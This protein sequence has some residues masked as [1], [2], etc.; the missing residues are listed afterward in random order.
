MALLFINK[1]LG[2]REAYASKVESISAKLGIDPDWLQF[3]IDFES[4]GSF[5]SSIENSYGCIGLIQFCADKSGLDYKT[6]DGEQIKLSTLKN[7][8]NVEQ[9]DWVYRYL[10]PYKG[11][12]QSYYDLY[13]AILWP[14]A[15]GKDDTYVIQTGTNP[16]F[17]LNKN[18]TITVAEVKQFL[19][20]RVKE[21]VPKNQQDS[22]KKKEIFCKYIKEKLLSAA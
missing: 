5:R 7:M 15:L 8:D 3:L 21:L 22:F 11:D 2:D 13:F 14:S 6:I 4:A 20:N 10:K 1:V 18:G 9:L 12:M 16:V 19:D 17:D